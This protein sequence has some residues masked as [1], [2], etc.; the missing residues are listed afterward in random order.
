M[1][2][3]AVLAFTSLILHAQDLDRKI[4]FPDTKEFKTLKCD[5][6]IHTVF[7]DGSVWPT[8][9]VDEAVRDGL[10][11]I[12][13]TD[14]IEYQPHKEDI[15]HPDRNRSFELAKKSAKPHDLLVIAGAEITRSLPPGHA[16]ALFVTDVNAIKNDDAMA[17]YKA[18]R[19]Q[20]AFI[21][22]N[23]PDWA[24]QQKN[25]IPKLYDFHKELLAN[26]LLHG[27][28]VVNDLTMSEEAM[29]IAIDNNMTVLGT[30]D[31]HGLVDY[32]F[33]VAKGGHRPICLVFA[34]DKSE[35]AIKEALFAGRTIA[36]FNQILIGKEAHMNP[37]LQA[38]LKFKVKGFI[39][40]SSVLEV[41]L[42]NESDAAF[43]LENTSK[44]D[45][46]SQISVFTIEPQSTLKL[47]IVTERDDIKTQALKLEVKN[48]VV[49]YR[50]YAG[51]TYS[52]DPGN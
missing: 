51:L 14:H 3:F 26:D 22:W 35:E 1:F 17:S 5:F 48:A 47:E 36:W 15:P 20:G 4:N 33:E 25:A 7:S 23:H 32:E 24:R 43:V 49:G 10:D 18:A 27:I 31:I 13:I 42:K 29:K 8:I 11:A 34:K 44:Y 2:F 12:A 16:N 6:H 45:F 40:D 41:E 21:F 19:A 38:C 50:K 39:G 30:S 9:R 52:L 37:F 46:R 28:E